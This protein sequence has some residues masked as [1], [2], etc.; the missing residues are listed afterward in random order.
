MN[1]RKELIEKIR[2]DTGLEIDPAWT[3]HNK[4]LSW[5]DRAIKGKYSWWFED[6]IGRKYGGVESM[7]QMLKA[8]KLVCDW[9]HPMN[10]EFYRER[11]KL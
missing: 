6:H 9:S 4:K 1:I 7:R 10:F 3:F 11:H 2:K 5:S 8:P